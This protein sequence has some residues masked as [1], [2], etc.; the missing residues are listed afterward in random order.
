ML[1]KPLF[2]VSQ[3]PLFKPEPLECPFRAFWQANGKPP[4]YLTEKV[5]IAFFN[6]RNSGIHLQ[7][8][9]ISELV[10]LYLL[11]LHQSPARVAH[12]LPMVSCP[13]TGP[14]QPQPRSPTEEVSF[15]VRDRSYRLCSQSYPH[16]LKWQTVQGGNEHFKTSGHYC[17]S[18]KYCY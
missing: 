5:T 6:A 7:F 10:S 17:N 13:S 2:C 3:R 9:L 16:L 18:G 12:I 11:F 14:T 4:R 15:N 8:V 1:Q